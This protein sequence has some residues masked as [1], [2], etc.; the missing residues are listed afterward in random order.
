MRRRQTGML[1]AMCAV[2]G[3]QAAHAADTRTDTEL[4]SVVVTATRVRAG[5]PDSAHVSG[6]HRQQSDS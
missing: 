4:Q 5:Q 3:G 6:P 2:A 1:I